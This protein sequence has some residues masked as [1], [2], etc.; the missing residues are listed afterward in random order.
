MRSQTVARIKTTAV[1]ALRRGDDPGF[2]AQA[3]GACG[4]GASCAAC[5]MAAVVPALAPTAGH[6]ESCAAL[7]ELIRKWIR[8]R[9]R[10]NADTGPAQQPVVAHSSP[11]YMAK[12]PNS[13]S[14]DI[15]I[16]NM[17]HRYCILPPRQLDPARVWAQRMYPAARGGISWTV[18]SLTH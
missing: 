2:L 11:G 15:Y 3:G 18:I 1:A 17:W 5:R 13:P 6:G 7:F 4:V 14:L 10:K 9:T 12:G 16:W 8:L